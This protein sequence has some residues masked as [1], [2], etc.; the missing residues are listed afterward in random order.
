MAAVGE[1]E[2][3]L[4]DGWISLGF[5]KL[6]NVL[7]FP[8]HTLFWSLISEGS[9]TL[10]F[11]SLICNCMFYGLVIERFYSLFKNDK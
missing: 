3:T 2:G 6:F 9:A 11:A 7:R 5:A 4:G 10:Y 1:D 8:T